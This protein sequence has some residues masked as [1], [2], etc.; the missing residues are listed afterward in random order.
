MNYLKMTMVNLALEAYGSFHYD[1][2]A[3]KPMS[4]TH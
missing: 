4:N 2:E 3:A 1:P